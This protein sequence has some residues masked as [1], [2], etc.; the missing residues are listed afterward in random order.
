MLGYR[1]VQQTGHLVLISDITH[2]TQRTDS[3]DFSQ[4]LG[5][6]GKSSLMDVGHAHS[7]PLLDRLSGYCRTDAH[8]RGRRYNHNPIN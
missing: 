1:C 5:G 2:A 6:L 8:P 4:S 7:G 3:R